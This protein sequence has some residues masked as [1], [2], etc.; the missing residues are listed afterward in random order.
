MKIPRMLQRPRGSTV[1]TLGSMLNSGGDV[2]DEDEPLGDDG[3]NPEPEE[4]EQQEEQEDF[5]PAED[6]ELVEA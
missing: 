6:R 1:S 2:F 4:T 3:N 5:D